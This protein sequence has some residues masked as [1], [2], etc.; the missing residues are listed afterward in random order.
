MQT[1]I[2]PNHEPDIAARGYALRSRS[3]QGSPLR[4]DRWRGA[5]RAAL[6]AAPLRA[7]LNYEGDVPLNPQTQ[8]PWCPDL[9]MSVAAGTGVAAGGDQGVNQTQ[10]RPL[11]PFRQ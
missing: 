11:V 9:L 4:S 6:T 2:Q 8:S 3:R 5:L 1:A 10:D 7:F